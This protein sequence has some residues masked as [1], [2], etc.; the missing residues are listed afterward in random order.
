MLRTAKSARDPAGRLGGRGQRGDAALGASGFAP[1]S[2]PP[3]D[4]SLGT[5][6]PPADRRHLR[7]LA[8]LGSARR[9]P[10]T[11]HALNLHVKREIVKAKGLL[12]T[13]GTAVSSDR[14]RLALP[15]PL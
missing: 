9:L 13:S 3:I 15:R 2:V 14:L 8:R 6:N 11:H 10:V 7:P 4:A 12:G 5:G 1:P